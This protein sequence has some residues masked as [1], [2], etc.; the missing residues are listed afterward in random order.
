MELSKNPTDSYWVNIDV[1]NYNDEI[2]YT[3][4]DLEGCTDYEITIIAVDKPGMVSLD[5]VT[6]SQKT[7]C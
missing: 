7:S 5:N 6:L 1:D 3:A 4:I 2:L